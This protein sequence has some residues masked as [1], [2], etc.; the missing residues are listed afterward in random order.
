MYSLCRFLLTRLLCGEG[1]DW[2]SVSALRYALAIDLGF[3]S[4]LSEVSMSDT[5][6]FNASSLFFVAWIAVIAGLSTAAFGRDLFPSEPRRDPAQ[7]TPAAKS[8]TR[9]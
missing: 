5:F 3:K 9:D 4:L 8:A 2:H 1:F 6:L 7:E